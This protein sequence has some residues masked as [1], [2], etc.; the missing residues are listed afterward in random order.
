RSYFALCFSLLCLGVTVPVLLLFVLPVSL[1][2][3]PFFFF[4]DTAPTEIYTLSLHDALPI[5]CAPH[6]PPLP[7]RDRGQ[8]PVPVPDHAD[9]SGGEGEEHPDDVQLDQPRHRGLGTDDQK[10]CGDRERDDAVAQRQPPA[11]GVQ[12]GGQIATLGQH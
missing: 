7:D 10:R 2:I 3:F 1:S 6:A 8:R 5:S 11:P 12:L 4:N 9:L